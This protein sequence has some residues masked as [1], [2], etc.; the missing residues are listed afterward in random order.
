MWARG[1][2]PVSKPSAEG[3]VGISRMSLLLDTCLSEFPLRRGDPKVPTQCSP[4]GWGPECPLTAAHTLSCPGPPG[5]T[6][7][8]TRSLEGP[9]AQRLRAG[10]RASPLG[11]GCLLSSSD[12]KTEEGRVCGGRQGRGPRGAEGNDD[13]VGASTTLA[14]RLGSLC[15]P[16]A[17][18]PAEARLEGLS[19]GILLYG[20]FG[21]APGGL[22]CLR[23]PLCF[24]CAQGS[25]EAGPPHRSLWLDPGGRRAHKSSRDAR[26]PPE[27]WEAWPPVET[28]LP[29]WK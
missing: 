18:P 29:P 25:R 3:T 23:P 9:G 14:S 16:G 15:L 4:G 20:R 7:W 6:C 27:S 11:S 21:A 5:S 19:R 28:S 2:E 10:R 17:G 24:L 8:G 13:K 1:P 12:S 22:P 26:L